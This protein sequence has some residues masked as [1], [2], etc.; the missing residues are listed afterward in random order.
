M[1]SI[2]ITIILLFIT[3]ITTA[4]IKIGGKLSYGSEI[5]SLGIGAKGVYELDETF[6]ISGELN[7][8]FGSKSSMSNTIQ[9]FDFGNSEF[10]NSL[11]T[12]NTDLHYNF[13]IPSMDAF[14]LYGIGGLNF[15]FFSAKTE[16]NSDFDVPGFPNSASANETFIGLNLGI[17]G[18]YPVSTNLDIISELK[19]V[20]SDLNQIIFSAGI[21]YSL[22]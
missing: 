16:I 1:K 18:A 5:E 22:N 8:F 14:S 21:V 19:Y 20:I 4:Q 17:G 11:V 9:G 12:L 3:T 6:S 2:K 15:S 10:K 13:N 7:Y